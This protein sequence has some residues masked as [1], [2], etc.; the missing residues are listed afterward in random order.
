MSDLN[1]FLGIEISHM[2]NGLFANQKQFATKVIERFKLTEASVVS[3][4]ADPHVKFDAFENGQI[5]DRVP[6]K[7]AI[8]SLLFLAMVTRPD[9]SFSVGVLSRYAENPTR[10]HWNGI[11]R[12]IKYLKGTL[13]YGIIL[14]KM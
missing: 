6:Y 10:A 9:L 11:K 8:G 1:V 3:I 7:E 14:W 5:A 2:P 12:I 4:P 13:D